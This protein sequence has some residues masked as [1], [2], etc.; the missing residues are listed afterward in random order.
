LG[1]VERRV[2]GTRRAAGLV[3]LTLLEVRP[4]R[5]R[6]GRLAYDKA[7]GLEPDEASLGDEVVVA[8]D[9]LG[10]GVGEWVLVGTGSRVR[11]L[12]FGDGAPLKAV[13]LAIVDRAETSGGGG[14]GDGAC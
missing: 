4:A 1:R 10:A 8:A 14:G 6:A 13:V 7:R 5:L 11:D 12:T 9:R 2:W 3:G